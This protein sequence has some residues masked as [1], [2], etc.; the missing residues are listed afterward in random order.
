MMSVEKKIQNKL[1]GEILGAA[2]IVLAVMLFA[3]TVEKPLSIAE[4]TKFDASA[5]YDLAQKFSLHQEIVGGAPFVYRL[6]TPFLVSLFFPGN[7]YWGFMVINITSAVISIF[8]LL[9]WLRL[10]LNNTFIRLLL[11]GLF[12]SHWLGVL[13]ITLFSPVH[14]ESIALVFNL[15]GFIIIFHLQRRPDNL[16]LVLAFCMITFIGVIFRESVILLSLVYLTLMVYG[17][18]I[19]SEIRAGVESQRRLLLSA[20]PFFSGVL[21]IF[22]TR[23]IAV[24]DGSFSM[25]A[26][27]IVWMYE[28]PLPSYIQS[29]FTTYGP[30]LAVLAPSI[31]VIKGFLVRE[32]FNSY[33]L[34]LMCVLA[35]GIGSDT[36]R[37]LYWAMPVVYV[38]FGV[39]LENLWQV[40]QHH[41][42]LL[43]VLLIAQLLAQRSFLPSQE[44]APEKI[45]Y[46]IPA[47][48][49][50]CNDG[51]GLDIPSYNGLSGSGLDAATCTPTP[52]LYFG[53]PYYLQLFLFSE[54]VLV[55]CIFAYLLT[56]AWHGRFGQIIPS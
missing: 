3:F 49:V 20:A 18:N 40:L 5:Y 52:C 31:G 29:Y 55:T 8:I 50:I 27:I 30:M 46:R 1:F 39:A 11:V 15:L 51:C 38:L 45:L 35:W 33:Y 4:G 48:T 44:Y 19:L 6:G 23:I 53:R 43:A 16:R 25:V 17:H 10:Y 54:N 56:R 13:R 36:D 42:G 14:V 24:P 28:K 32:K 41:R 2:I 21:A 9:F 12:A 22:L 37:F 34:V 47:L 26:A 7:L